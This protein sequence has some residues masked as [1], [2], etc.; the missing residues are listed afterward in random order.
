VRQHEDRRPN[1]AFPQLPADLQTVAAW[2]HDVE[3]DGVVRRRPGHPECFL[4]CPRDVGGVAFLDETAADERRHLGLVLD[5]E[6]AHAL[7]VV[8]T[9]PIVLASVKSACVTAS[10]VS[11]DETTMRPKTGGSHRG[12]M[13]DP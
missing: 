6:R 1:A 3:D 8:T 9:R 11:F 10:V 12:L 7:I 13:G 5:Y 2:E 4:P